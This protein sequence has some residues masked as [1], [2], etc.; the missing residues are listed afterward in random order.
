M[1]EFVEWVKELDIQFDYE[2]SIRIAR[3]FDAGEAITTE[4]ARFEEIGLP[5]HVHDDLLAKIEYELR[6]EAT[7][8]GLPTN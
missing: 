8:Y 3:L 7:K 5:T 1:R 4:R 2:R 6:A